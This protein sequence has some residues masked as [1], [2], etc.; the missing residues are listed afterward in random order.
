MGRGV[1]PQSLTKGIFNSAQMRVVVIYTYTH[2]SRS[3]VD[4]NFMLIKRLCRPLL[5]LSFFLS[6]PVLCKIAEK[7]FVLTLLSLKNREDR[8]WGNN[9]LVQERERRI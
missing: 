3:E 2:R 9:I 1:T 5:P 6:S 8:E 4:Y 7:S